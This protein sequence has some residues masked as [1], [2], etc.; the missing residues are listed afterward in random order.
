MSK[1]YDRPLTA[2]EL[3]K[4]RDE[5]I[6]FSDIPELDEQWFKKAVVVHADSKTQLTLRL[7]PEVVLWFRS[8]GPGYQTR[9]NAVLR[10]YYDAQSAAKPPRVRR[11]GAK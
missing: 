10:A 2:D 4:L 3:R 8:Q 6:D 11:A 5:D 9:M 1:R 7:D